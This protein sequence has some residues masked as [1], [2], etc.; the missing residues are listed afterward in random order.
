MI[1]TID[2]M[3]L[4]RDHRYRDELARTLLSKCGRDADHVELRRT[5]A[6]IF[7]EL[8]RDSGDRMLA[9]IVGRAATLRVRALP[10]D[11]RDVTDARLQLTP[12]HPLPY[13]ENYADLDPASRSTLLGFCVRQLQT[14]CDGPVTL[15]RL[16]QR[17]GWPYSERTFYVGP[18]KAARLRSARRH[19]DD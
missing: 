6:R 13:P 4:G 7:P 15:Q 16:L 19:N 5:A 11:D 9:S 14:G 2:E 17:H 12:T 8:R 10:R 3:R 18:W 1:A